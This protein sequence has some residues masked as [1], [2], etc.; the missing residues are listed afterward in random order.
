M[1]LHLDPRLHRAAYVVVIT[2]GVAG[3]YVFQRMIRQV[4]EK[5]TGMRMRDPLAWNRL[6]Y[7]EIQ[8]EYR[9]AFPDGNLPR[10]HRLLIILFVVALGIAA[11]SY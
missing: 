3:N 10:I 7:P 1:F 8:K 9:G 6:S 11:L 4:T 5:R 2:T